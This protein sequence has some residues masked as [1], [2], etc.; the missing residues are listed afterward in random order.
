MNRGRWGRTGKRNIR[1]LTDAIIIKTIK[2]MS[3]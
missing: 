1:R 3:L 2:K